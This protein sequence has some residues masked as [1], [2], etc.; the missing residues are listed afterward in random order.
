M[1]RLYLDIETY[2]E[3]AFVDETIIA[4]GVLEDW[5]SYSEESLSRVP[6][7]VASKKVCTS[8]CFRLFN[9]WELGNE[10]TVIRKFY[11]YLKDLK[12]KTFNTSHFLVITGFNI[13]RFDIPLLIQKG[14]KYRIDSLSNLNKL[15]HDMFVIDL[16]QVALPLN[17]MRFKRNTLENLADKARKYGIDIPPL[18]GRGKD[19]PKLYKEGKYD[20]IAE[21]LERDLEIVRHLD[22]TNAVVRVLRES[23]SNEE[24]A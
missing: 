22:L 23:S 14:V 24:Y 4:V 16:F 12:E 9:E 6:E 8:V 18:I 20:K 15:W 19:I 3:S 1:T 13:L 5:T 11:K 2:R 17:G 7:K 10:K 21:H